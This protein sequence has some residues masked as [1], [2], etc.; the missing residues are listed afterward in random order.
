MWHLLDVHQSHDQAN[1]T[2][3]A[4]SDTSGSLEAGRAEPGEVHIGKELIS[5]VV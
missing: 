3:S 5:D 1:L 2:L 4:R